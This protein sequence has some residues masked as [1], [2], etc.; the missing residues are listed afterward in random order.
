MP[1]AGLHVRGRSVGVPHVVGEQVFVD[2]NV[3]HPLTWI[4]IT[5]RDGVRTPYAEVPLN[6]SPTITTGIRCDHADA[7]RLCSSV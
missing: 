5:T 4:T 3:S 1:N 2:G 6:D 7:D